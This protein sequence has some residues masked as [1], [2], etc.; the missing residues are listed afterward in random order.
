MQVLRIAL[1]FFQ[2]WVQGREAGGIESYRAA[3][4]PFGFTSGKEAVCD[5]TFHLL[6]IV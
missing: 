5:L 6:S 1:L 4:A 2:N 3:L